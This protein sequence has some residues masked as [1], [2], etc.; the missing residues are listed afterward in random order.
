M[1]KL[2][3][4]A[5]VLMLLSACSLVQ[6]YSVTFTTHEVAVVNTVSD[7]LDF[8]LSAP[9]LAYISSYQC[10]GSEKVELLPIVSEESVA[11]KAYNLSLVPLVGKQAGSKC[12]VNITAFDKTTTANSSAK[13]S[14]YLY[15]KPTPVAQLNEFCGGIAAIQCADALTC[16]LDGSFPD[17]GGVCAASS[18]VSEE[19]AVIPDYSEQIKTCGEAGGTWNECGSACKDP[20][21]ICIQVCVPQCEFPEAVSQE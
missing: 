11:A 19:T 13:I 14:L 8:V 21:Q 7:T 16:N 6:P 12:E 17:A 9:A 10:E 20:N 18:P 4:S 1:K 2:F 15:S 3:L 5:T